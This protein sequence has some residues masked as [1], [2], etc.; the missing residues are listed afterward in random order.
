[1]P[2]RDTRDFL[3]FRDGDPF[4]IMP[5]APHSARGFCASLR[6]RFPDHDWAIA[7]RFDP[8]RTD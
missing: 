5:L 7:S 8:A 6:R 2:R 3:I 4:R 1:M